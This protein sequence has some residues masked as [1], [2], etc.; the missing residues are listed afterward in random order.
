MEYERKLSSLQHIPAILK[1]ELTRIITAKWN[2]LLHTIYSRRIQAYK[3]RTVFW[4]LDILESNF[5][6]LTCGNGINPW[7][8]V[9]IGLL[10]PPKKKETAII[11]RGTQ[12]N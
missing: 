7:V 6:V 10:Q 9:S 3:H 5:G 4:V 11:A 12:K 1:A 8:L 2:A